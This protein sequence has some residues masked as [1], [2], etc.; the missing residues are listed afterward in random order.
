MKAPKK[1]RYPRKPK[2]P[3]GG[4][5]SDKQLKSYEDSVKRYN[6][7]V[8]KI[9]SKYAKDL[10]AYNDFQKRVIKVKNSLK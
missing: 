8:T 10:K 5:K 6:D 1:G 3:K 4:I 2:L 7:K 9:E